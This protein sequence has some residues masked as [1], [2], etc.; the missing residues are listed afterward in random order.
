MHNI[1]LTDSISEETLFTFMEAI[2]NI[3]DKNKI[4]VYLNSSGG[5]PSLVPIF[6]DIIERHQ[7]RL[8]GACEVS[9][10]AL[11]LFLL[12]NT[13]RTV[14]DETECL[15]HR[16]VIGNTTTDKFGKSIRDKGI[17]KIWSEF[18]WDDEIAYLF[19]MSENEIREMHEGK[20]FYFNSEDLRKALKKSEEKFANKK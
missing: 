13:P 15:V 10:A 12:T 8:V 18:N 7:M 16:L 9:S 4:V 5:N 11:D 2:N 1:L 14:L 19:S 6:R 20:E 17:L 3:E